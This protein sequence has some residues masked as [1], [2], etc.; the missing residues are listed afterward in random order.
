MSTLGTFLEKMQGYLDRRFWV[1]H[2]APVLIA[3]LWGLGIYVS[4]AGFAS[5]LEWLMKLTVAEQILGALSILVFTTVLAYLM[6]TISVPM[7]R[8]YDGYGMEGPLKK[9]LLGR[10]TNDFAGLKKKLG[11]SHP[12]EPDAPQ[13]DQREFGQLYYRLYLEFPR[14]PGLLR[15]TRLGNALTSAEEYPYQ[16]YQ[17]DAVLWWPRLV[18]L[19]PESFQAQL[20]ASLT[21]VFALLN[22]ATFSVLVGLVELAL[23]VALDRPVWLALLI[24]LIGLVLARVFYSAA[25]SQALQYGMFVRVAFDLY[26]REILKQMQIALP[27]NL[28]S[29]RRLWTALNN[30]IYQ[31]VPPWESN[32]AAEEENL[33]HPFFYAPVDA[34]G[35]D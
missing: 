24:A 6:G 27:D 26:R 33:A 15:P 29:E 19:L 11:K 14:S 16:V 9:L 13:G 3:T 7:L 22:L 28:V 20:D 8:L 2:W 32:V 18:T 1:A 25:V 12:V 5:N 17:L 34:A 21:P 35:K 30:W 10:Q 4:L 31:F 23:A